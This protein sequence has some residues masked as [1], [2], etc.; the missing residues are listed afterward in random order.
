MLLCDAKGIAETLIMHD[1]ALAQ[2]AQGI[3]HIGIVA[4]T[5]QVVVGDACLLLCCNLKSASF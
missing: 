4:K 1:L 3:D 5:D 2:I